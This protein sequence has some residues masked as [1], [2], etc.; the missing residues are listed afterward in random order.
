M[1]SY[2]IQLITMGHQL[3]SGTNTQTL[4]HYF[5]IR[6][7]SHEEVTFHTFGTETS[8]NHQINYKYC[9]YQIPEILYVST[10]GHKVISFCQAL[11]MY[12]TLNTTVV[13]RPSL[14]C[15]IIEPRRKHDPGSPNWIHY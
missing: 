15:P 10:N 6:N 5:Y 4:F 14:L 7:F 9:K 3:L 12:S 1:G 8:M 2:T 13:T 11:G